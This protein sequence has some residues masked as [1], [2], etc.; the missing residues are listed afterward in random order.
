M[1]GERTRRGK[2][3]F[4]IG[5]YHSTCSLLT[6]SLSFDPFEFFT[7]SGS[8]SFSTWTEFALQPATSTL[9]PYLISSCFVRLYLQEQLRPFIFF[10]ATLLTTCITTDYNDDRNCLTLIKMFFF[11][12]LFW[13][14]P[15]A[16][17]RF[18]RVQ[19]SQSGSFWILFTP[20][21]SY[22][23]KLDYHFRRIIMSLSV[24]LPM[25]KFELR[26]G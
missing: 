3:I 26:H 7:K 24:K 14:N 2:T 16:M 18:F 22:S 15:V 25:V 9:S 17:S 21:E 12:F 6:S 23:I 8:F 4:F 1:R 11:R 20:F 19:L 13:F 5:H 10:H